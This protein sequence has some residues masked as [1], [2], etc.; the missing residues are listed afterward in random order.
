MIIRDFTEQDYPELMQLWESTGLGNPARGD[1]LTVITRTLS[2]GGKMLVMINPDDGRL[3]GSSWI[4]NDGRRL[5]LH[6]FGILPPYQHKGLARKLLDAS[7][8]FAGQT[9]LQIKLEVH[10][11]NTRAVELYKRAGF[12]D[13]GDYRVYIIRKYSY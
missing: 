9:G 5:Y 7:L 1:D 4:T 2:M 10:Q 3:I 13:L 11:T 8:E 12:K 6:H